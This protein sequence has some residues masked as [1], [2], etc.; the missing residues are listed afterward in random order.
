VPRSILTKEIL[1]NLQHDP[2]YLQRNNFEVLD[3]SGK[4]ILADTIRWKRY[5]RDQLPFILRQREGSEN[6]MGI[7]KFNFPN[8]YGVYLH[9]TN[10]KRL[11]ELRRRDLSHGCVRV[12]DAVSLA[13]YMVREDDIYVSPEDLDQY[14]SLRQRL[15]IDLR[16]PIHLKL[17]YIT[18][19]VRNGQPVFYDDIYKKDSI[20]LQRLSPVRNEIQSSSAVF[21]TGD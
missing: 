7:I 17:A 9:D 13:H 6:S 21:Q 14:L 15:A 2:L 4:V 11:Y 3:K 19:E 8:K 16:K 10:S 1:P 18:A 5:N 20:M 12:K